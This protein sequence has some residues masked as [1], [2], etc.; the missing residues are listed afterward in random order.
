MSAA[1]GATAAG[2]L[3]VVEDSDE[4]FDTV[5]EAV[6][7]AGLANEVRR[8]TTSD[9][10]L[11]LLRRSG[12]A[13]VRPALVLLDLNLPGTDGREALCQIRADA[14]LG[15]LTVVVLSTSANPRDVSS[16]Y[17]LGAN[18]YHVKPVRHQDHLR[19][20]FDVFAYWLTKVSLPE[21][22]SYTS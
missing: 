12:D 6:Q 8:A 16:C 20:L 18:A 5:R 7:K 9:E 17:R 15:G 2:P 1:R 4:D 13:I 10:C 19:M 21:L 11:A 14:R 22:E 3:L